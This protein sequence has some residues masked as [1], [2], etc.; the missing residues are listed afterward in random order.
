MGSIKKVRWSNGNLQGKTTAS[1]QPFACGDSAPSAGEDGP[2]VQ[3]I[4]PPRDLN[5]P[6]GI[7]TTRRAKA[8]VNWMG[9]IILFLDVIHSLSVSEAATF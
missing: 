2:Y 6:G 1:Y 9:S 3:A 4:A 5:D 8:G 7:C